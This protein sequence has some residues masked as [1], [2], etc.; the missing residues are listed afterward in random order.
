M[1]ESPMLCGIG[2]LTGCLLMLMF[3]PA[4]ASAGAPPYEAQIVDATPLMV[5]EI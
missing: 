2:G 1:F 5:N 3:I 4:G